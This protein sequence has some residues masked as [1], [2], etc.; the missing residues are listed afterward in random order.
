MLVFRSLSLG[1]VG[2]C[3][4]MLAFR[5][6]YEIRF[7]PSPALAPP[8]AVHDSATIVDVAAGVPPGQLSS[9]IRLAA[10]E[11]VVA[12]DDVPVADDLAA[13]AVIAEHELH[14]GRYVDL[15]VAGDAGTRRVLV[16]LH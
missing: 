12:V 3:F 7:A 5:P 10:N 14:T 11:H 15:E 2:A 6:A 16:L 8:P 13:G 9:L 4:L 1:L